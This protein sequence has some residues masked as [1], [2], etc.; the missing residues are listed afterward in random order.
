MFHSS[1]VHDD[2]TDGKKMVGEK[3]AA[4]FDANRRAGGMLNP[5]RDKN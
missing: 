1:C 2:L 4:K 3:Y 5:L